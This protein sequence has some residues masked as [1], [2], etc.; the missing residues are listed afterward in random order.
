MIFSM[1]LLQAAVIFGAIWLVFGRR[2]DCFDNYDERIELVRRAENKVPMQDRGR[3]SSAADES[4][5]PATMEADERNTLVVLA[6]CVLMWATDSLHHI[7]AVY[8]GLATVLILT[9]PTFGPLSFTDMRSVNFPALILMTSV[10]GLGGAFAHDHDIRTGIS[11]PLVDFITE[12]A[13]SEFGRY[14]LTVVVCVPVLWVMGTSATAGFASALLVK[15]SLCVCVC[16]GCSHMPVSSGAHRVGFGPRTH[17]PVCCLFNGCCLAALPV[18][19]LPHRAELQHV[20]GARL[21]ESGR[22]CHNHQLCRVDSA[23][24]CHL[25]GV[26]T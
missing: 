11:T 22:A 23:D 18:L 6:L 15:V 24:H 16:L 3:S 19:A 5:P 2:S 13:S 20:H 8:I 10:I 12:H 25:A 14:Y 17:W 9:F 21:R 1:W 7:Q 4:T 26:A